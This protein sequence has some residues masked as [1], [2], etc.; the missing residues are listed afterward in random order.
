MTKRTFTTSI[1]A[2][3][4]AGLLGACGNDGG[5][6]DNSTGSGEASAEEEQDAILEYA[7]C[8]RDHGVD[9]PDPE[10]GEDGSVGAEPDLDET[11]AS[12][13]T[14]EAAKVACQPILDAVNAGGEHPDA[15]D[16]AETLDQMVAVTECMRATGYD[17]ADPSVGDDG[18][19]RAGSGLPRD[20]SQEEIEQQDADLEDCQDQA[21]IDLSASEDEG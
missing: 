21:G 15:Q 16:A 7:Q 14:I 13:E 2:L 4:L 8:M 1:V 19:I 5:A 6:D 12:Q 18:E 3:A 9:V 17:M 11:G 10:I 20:A